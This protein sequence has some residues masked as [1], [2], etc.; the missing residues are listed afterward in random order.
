MDKLN[1]LTKF[2]QCGARYAQ[3]RDWTWIMKSIGAVSND[4]IVRKMTVV[5][6]KSRE[7]GC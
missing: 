6:R 4:K 7:R 5:F 1:L 3:K 2:I